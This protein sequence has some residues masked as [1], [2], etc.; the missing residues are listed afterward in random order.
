M[1]CR[2]ACVPPTTTQ[3]L[4]DLVRRHGE[5]WRPVIVDACRWLDETEAA[6]QAEGLKLP[7]TS[8]AGYIKSVLRKARRRA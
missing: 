4:E 2:I 5:A 3:E 8:R 6:M 1:T 7:R